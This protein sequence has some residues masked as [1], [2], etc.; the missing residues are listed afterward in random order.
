MKKTLLA[1]TFAALALSAAVSCQKDDINKPV[2][3]ASGETANCYIVSAEGTYSFP[4]VKG[5][6]AEPVGAVSSAELLWEVSR[7]STD[8]T[9]GNLI[10]N[11]RYEGGKIVFSASA[12]KGNAVIAARDAAG[13]I[14]WSWHIWMTDKPAEQVYNNGAGTMMDRNLGAT[15]ATP[16]DAGSFGLMYQ[17]GRKDPFCGVAELAS[18]KSTKLSS[19]AQWPEAVVSDATTGTIEYA[20]AHPMT[21]IM[22]NEYNSDWYYRDDYTTED[23]RW[24]AE[25]TIYDPC[26]AGWRVPGGCPDGIWAKALGST[27]EYIDSETG[28][29]TGES[30][31][32]LSKTVPALASGE[33][34]W[35]PYEGLI[36]SDSGVLSGIL[37]IAGYWSVATRNYY[38][39]VFSVEMYDTCIIPYSDSPRAHG[40]SLRC[41]KVK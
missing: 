22:E 40:C 15:S 13:T 21:F 16:D 2:D 37:E 29:D 34:V 28:W 26:P 32:D 20:L 8:A 3:L 19:K 23:T 4:A 7:T 35:Y 14:L 38:G 30:G 33:T 39:Y 17:W 18:G 6:S 10:S 1:L 12:H 25:K 41:M 24:Q 5:N 27:E 31:A 11:V 9:D 36:Y